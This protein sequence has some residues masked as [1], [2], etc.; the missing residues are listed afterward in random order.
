MCLSQVHVKSTASTDTRR[1]TTY[2]H[3]K[4]PMSLYSN[5]ASSYTEKDRSQERQNVKLQEQKL[6]PTQRKKQYTCSC[7]LCDNAQNAHKFVQETDLRHPDHEQQ[8]DW[9]HANLHMN[10]TEVLDHLRIEYANTKRQDQHSVYVVKQSSITCK[11]NRQTQNRQDQHSGY[12]VKQSSIT[13][14]SNTQTQNRQDM[15]SLRP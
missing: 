2:T 7:T 12:V 13:Y 10:T 5:S 14:T 9:V 3:M 1:Q 4:K 15:H 8:G 11:S 6:A